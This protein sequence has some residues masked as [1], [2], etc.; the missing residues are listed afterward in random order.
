[1]ETNDIGKGKFKC[2]Y[3]GQ[4]MGNDCPKSSVLKGNNILQLS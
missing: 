1:M 4:N 2:K 3:I